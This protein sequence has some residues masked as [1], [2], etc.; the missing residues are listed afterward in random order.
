MSSPV[1]NG[2]TRPSRV[3]V[4]FSGKHGTDIV[5][6]AMACLAARDCDVDDFS[7]S[8]STWA[9]MQLAVTF[10]AG[11]DPKRVL[12]ELSDIAR[13]SDCIIRYELDE[14]RRTSLEGNQRTKLSATTL[15]EH[16]L[17]P[18]FLHLWTSLLDSFDIQIDRVERLN[19]GSIRV[20]DFRLTVPRATDMAEF[21]AKTF[22]LSVEH[23]TDIAIM[24][25]NVYRK[26]KR[27][28]VFDMDSTLIQQEVID[29]L[30][31]YAGV[32]DKV[33]A[34]TEAAM[35]GEI[36]FKESLR[37][38]VSLLAGMGVETLDRVREMIV[39]TEGARQLCRALKRLGYRLAVISGGFLPLALH[40]KAELNLDYAFANQLEVSEDGKTFTG[41]TLGP[42]IDGERKAELLEVLAQ[43]EALV[44]DQVIAVGDGA[45]DLWML[46]KAG[47]GIAFNAKKRVQ[48]KAPA[49]INQKSLTNVLY[50]LGYND[51]EIAGLLS[52]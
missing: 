9:D 42:I 8:Q 27:L 17:S 41:K 20:A 7:L 46:A 4:S 39:F 30:A 5:A 10:S 52:D 15:N 36:D 3:Y 2:T 48:E 33:S 21:R 44:Y 19:E 38:R 11:G 6:K 45:N 51:K 29:E 35:N 13:S 49:R 22:Q 14:S 50:L 37:R 1:L 40:V 12:E 23:A 18:Q 28:V 47:L 31:K 32:V 26:N 34:I 43:A 16:G 25:Y 24:P